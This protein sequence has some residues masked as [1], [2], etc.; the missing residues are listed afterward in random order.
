MNTKLDFTL[1]LGLGE[2]HQVLT[3]R[4]LKGTSSSNE[5]L[6]LNGVLDS[7]KSV[8]DG[9]LGLSDRIVIRTLDQNS[10]GEGVLDLLDESVFIITK[11]LLVYLTSKTEIVFGQV[12]DGIDLSSSASQGDSLTISLL[13]SSDTNDTIVGEHF[14]GWGINTLLVDHNEVLAILRSANL[15]L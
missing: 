5:D 4:D 6:I 13:A 10:A 12:I 14:E 3:S 7:T 2:L 1:S 11:N 15:S 9:L 8:T